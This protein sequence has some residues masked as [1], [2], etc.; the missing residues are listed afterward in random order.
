MDDPEN[1]EM[2]KD[3]K[4]WLIRSSGLFAM[5]SLLVSRGNSRR[6]KSW[7][8]QRNAGST[9]DRR[10]RNS[11]TTGGNATHSHADSSVTHHFCMRENRIFSPILLC[12]AD[13]TL[14][15]GCT[16]SDNHHLSTANG[17][18]PYCF[19]SGGQFRS[20]CSRFGAAATII[21]EFGDV[22]RRRELFDA[23]SNDARWNND[24]SHARWTTIDAS[25]IGECQPTVSTAS[26]TGPTTVH[27]DASRHATATCR[28]HAN[29]SRFA[30]R[31]KNRVNLHDRLFF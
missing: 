18:C 7:L 1:S 22:Q 26:S 19:E 23:W 16:Q 11:E 2:L 25:S 14:S 27:A 8:D 4:V 15:S 17:T 30:H 20:R 13:G 31:R 21:T 5:A 24:C 28:S 10:A 3:L 9:A 6:K 12:L 29:S